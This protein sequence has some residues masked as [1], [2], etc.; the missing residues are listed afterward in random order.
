MRFGT[1]NYL[2]R[3]V[4]RSVFE[5]LGRL[6]RYAS[7]LYS[8]VLEVAGSPLV[9][10]SVRGFVA[11]V[12]RDTSIRLFGYSVV[13]SGLPL[14][15]EELFEHVFAGV[16][17]WARA[18]EERVVLRD[19]VVPKRES[20]EEFAKSKAYELLAACLERALVSLGVVE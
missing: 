5:E 16:V 14:S 19:G 11:R 18:N 1:A 20:V 7:Y 6:D 2:P 12:C 15:F 10:E 4:L 8:K 17:E 9:S 3:S 13:P